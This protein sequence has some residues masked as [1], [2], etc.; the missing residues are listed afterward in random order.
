MGWWPATTRER[1]LGRNRQYPEAPERVCPELVNLASWRLWRPRVETVRSDSVRSGQKGVKKVS[2]K[3]GFWRGKL[4][5]F[6]GSGM[7]RTVNLEGASTRIIN[8]IDRS[9]QKCPKWHFW[10][11]WS[12]LAILIQNPT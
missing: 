6:R 1:P 10:L 8:G 9:V 5:S 11:F 7:A 3:G 2:Q 12:I 4:T